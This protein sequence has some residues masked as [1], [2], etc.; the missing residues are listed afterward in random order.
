MSALGPLAET[1]TAFAGI[2][3]CA[4]IFESPPEEAGVADEGISATDNLI[5][6]LAT[7]SEE[8]IITAPELVR[9]RDEL[10]EGKLV[11]P[12]SAEDVATKTTSMIHS[13][14]MQ[15]LLEEGDLDLSKLLAW[16]ESALKEKVRVRVRREETRVETEEIFHKIEFRPVPAGEF[17][18]GV[19]GNKRSVTLTHPFEMMTSSITQNQWAEVMGANPSNFKNGPDSIIRNIQDKSIQMRPDHP[20]EDFTWWSV[21]VFAN[22][23]SEKYGLKPSY[24]LSGVKFKPGTSAE[25]GTLETEDPNADALINA[26]EGNIYLAE[27]YRLPT[28][29]ER[30]RAT[31][32][33]QTHFILLETTRR[34]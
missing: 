14:A 12:I 16:S 3:I 18:M 25:S 26:P 31:R 24:D 8:R 27:G 33:E 6:Y 23:L 11:N 7:L 32:G 28:E 1:H 13:K 34:I 2:T 10:L 20:V 30:E 15:S 4:E 29:A 5:A 17:K 19:E 22:R 21:I 9:F